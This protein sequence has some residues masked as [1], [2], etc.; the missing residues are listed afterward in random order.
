MLNKLKI[1]ILAAITSVLLFGC[2]ATA[3]Q[4]VVA[5]DNGAVSTETGANQPSQN[6][7]SSLLNRF[8]SYVC[9]FDEFTRKALVRDRLNKGIEDGEIMIRCNNDILTKTPYPTSNVEFTPDN[10]NL[11]AATVVPSGANDG[12]IVTS[13]RGWLHR[14]PALTVTSKVSL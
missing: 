2:L 8:V 4:P 9:Q 1:A 12:L 10:P 7:L 13:P 11:T 14:E 5:T 6:Y 3:G